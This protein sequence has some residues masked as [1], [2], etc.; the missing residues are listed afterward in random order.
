MPEKWLLSETNNLSLFYLKVIKM[1][2]K[3]GFNTNGMGILALIILEVGYHS[4]W[5]FSWLTI[6][7]GVIVGLCFV[8]LLILVDET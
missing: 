6:L 5:E 2:K 8:F 1:K 4:K 7:I 3:I